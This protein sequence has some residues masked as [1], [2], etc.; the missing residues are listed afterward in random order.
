MLH[1]VV[2]HPAVILAYPLD[3]A[4]IAAEQPMGITHRHLK[5]LFCLAPERTLV[6]K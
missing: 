1:P 5:E 4:V 3:V 6:T 2:G